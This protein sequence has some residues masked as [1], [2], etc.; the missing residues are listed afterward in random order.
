[1]VRSRCGLSFDVN[2]QQY[3]FITDVPDNKF[4]AVNMQLI[5]NGTGEYLGPIVSVGIGIKNG[6]Y[7]HQNETGEY[8]VRL[9]G[10]TNL[11]DVS[12][13]FGVYLVKGRRYK[14]NYNV[15]SIEEKNVVLKN[16][17][18]IGPIYHDEIEMIGEISHSE[19]VSYGEDGSYTMETSV[20]GNQF[21][22]AI[23]NLI[24]DDINKS[25][26]GQ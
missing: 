16:Y 9:K 18:F 10:N 24:N 3:V 26:K 12:I 13:D 15:I 7:M 22:S 23:L 1:M 20:E 2:L 11:K 8:V 19:G 17:S 21:N 6:F 25:C 14:Y 5:K 4:N